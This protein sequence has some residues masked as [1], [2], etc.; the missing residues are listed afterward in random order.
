MVENLS[1]FVDDGERK[2]MATQ[3]KKSESSGGV[4]RKLG[5]HK[6]IAVCPRT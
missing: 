6:K 1:G 3:G 2:A 5:K 4:V